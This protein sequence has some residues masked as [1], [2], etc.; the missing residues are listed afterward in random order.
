[1]LIIQTATT[2]EQQGEL[3]ID[4][5]MLRYVNRIQAPLFHFSQ[6]HL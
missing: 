1:V 2:I 5:A 4:T 6:Q 3:G